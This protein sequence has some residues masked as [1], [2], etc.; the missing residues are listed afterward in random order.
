MAVEYLVKT[1]AL[2]GFRELVAQLGRNP[3]DI[4]RNAGV[5]I[6]VLEDPDRFIPYRAFLDALNLAAERTGTPHFGLLLSK[7]QRL[8]ILGKLGMAMNCAAD[9]GSAISILQEKFHVTSTGSLSYLF[10][11]GDKAE[12]RFE[13]RL[14]DHPSIQQQIDLVAGTGVAIFKSLVRRNDAIESIYLARRRPKDLP[15][16]QRI[17]GTRV[18]FD[19]PVSALRFDRKLLDLPLENSNPELFQ[20]MHEYLSQARFGLPVE[21][22]ERVRDAIVRGL[23]DQDASIDTISRLL[24]LEPRTLQRRLEKEGRRFGDLLNDVRKDLAQRYLRET[25]M[26]LTDVSLALNYSDP[27]TFTRFFKRRF[28]MTPSM[29]RNKERDA[30]KPS[31]A[32]PEH[33]SAI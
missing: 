11:D 12:W 29:W 2:F 17:L 18:V 3:D 1:S 31:I 33:S 27:A 6:E 30:S 32:T 24:G 25:T 21:F 22:S 28:G 26:S 16:Y 15:L 13:V 14:P 10:H 20:V 4:L 9:V 23:H 8:S 5:D 19:Q 7:Q